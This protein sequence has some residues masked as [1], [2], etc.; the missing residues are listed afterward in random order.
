MK[1]TKAGDNISELADAA[2][3]ALADA[4]E[5]ERRAK[6]DRRLVPAAKRARERVDAILR[7][8]AILR[9]ETPPPASNAEEELPLSADAAPATETE[10]E[11]W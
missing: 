9:G 3:H 4:V 7:R 8:L 1:A 5:L 2:L 11:P 6:L 10:D